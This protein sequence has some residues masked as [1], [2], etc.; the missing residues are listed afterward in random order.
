MHVLSHQLME[1]QA[2]VSSC[3]QE[4]LSAVSLI[5]AF[6]SEVR[7]VGRLMSELKGAMQTSL[8]QSTVNSAANMAIDSLPGLARAVVVAHRISTFRDSDRILLLN[9]NR[10]VAMGTHESLWESNGYYRSLVAYQQMSKETDLS[11]GSRM[12]SFPGEYA[13]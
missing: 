6:S 8:E 5:K 12:G 4:S 1:Q 11:Q 9:E 10:L 7:T 13:P 3:F 2:Q